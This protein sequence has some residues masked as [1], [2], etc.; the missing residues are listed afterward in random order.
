MNNL[1]YALKNNNLVSIEEV[2]SGENCGCI[3][4]SCK[5]V[6]VAK[7]GSLRLHHFAHKSN[8]TCKYG[9]ETSLHLL[10]K[11]IIE[12]QNKFVIPE[13]AVNCGCDK[14]II[15]ES[16]QINISN[17]YVEKNL[18]NVKPDIILEILNKNNQIQKFA[19]EIYV[20]HKIDDKKLEKIKSLN[21]STIEIDLSEINKEIEKNNIEFI[22]QE[23]TKIIFSKN[24]KR[25]YWVF[26]K[27]K[28]DWLTKNQDKKLNTNNGIVKCPNQ[29]YININAETCKNCEHLIKFSEKKYYIFCDQQNTNKELI[30]NE[31]NYEE[32]KIEIIFPCGG[33]KSIAIVFCPYLKYQKYRDDEKIW[34][35]DKNIFEK[36]NRC[37]DCNY[38]LGMNLDNGFL[39]CK[40][41]NA[42]KKY[43]D[44]C[45][46]CE[47]KLI[48][49]TG[50]NGDFIGCTN[51]PTCKY[52]RDCD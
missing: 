46:K 9:Y 50:L 21:L 19:V 22:E 35:F 15:R 47:N 42:Y 29:N 11:K 39:Y 8:S 48:K 23:I 52:T 1:I 24:D 30:N 5:Q 26:N 6:L 4:P 31:K 37:C 18:E 49:K 45:P 38:Y 12:K 2:E 33:D 3:C 14:I 44:I 25:K 28:N 40:M 34:G 13:L 16:I 17:V 27:Y 36:D 10:A 7:K 32:Y 41:K 51:Y 20:T 43:E